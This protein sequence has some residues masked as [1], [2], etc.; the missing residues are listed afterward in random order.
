MSADVPPRAVLASLD[1]AALAE[2]VATSRSWRQVGRAVGLPSSRHSRRLRSLCDQWAIDYS[3]FRNH[4][5]SDEQLVE[6]LGTAAS[7]A[8]VLQLLGYAEDSGSARATIRRHARRLGLPTPQF[9]PG[10]AASDDA[11]MPEPRRSHLRDAGPTLV[12]ATCMLS[13]YR[14]SW[15]LEPAP[16]DLLVDTGTRLMRVQVK[17]CTRMTGGSWVCSLTRSEY[18]DVAGG[19]RRAWYSPED[20]DVFAIVDGEGEVYWIPV[21]R[22][23]GQATVSLRRYGAFR[24]P[25]LERQVQ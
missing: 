22:V 11:S 19:K 25:R 2:A 12:A 9:A 16:Y 15:P 5:F 3:H 17:T 18:A 7:W 1:A 4:V 8:Q 10:P 14:V 13:G 20:I 23:D 6:V 24:V 21:A